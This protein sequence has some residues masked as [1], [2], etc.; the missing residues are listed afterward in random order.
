MVCSGIRYNFPIVHTIWEG[1]VWDHCA[2]V[3]IGLAE[4]GMA[5]ILREVDLLW[6]VL[7]IPREVMECIYTIEEARHKQG[8]LQ[9]VSLNILFF[10]FFIIF[11]SIVEIRV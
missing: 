1:A 2:E 8:L 7:R 4:E 6:R 5:T 10:K 11:I 3:V 9:V